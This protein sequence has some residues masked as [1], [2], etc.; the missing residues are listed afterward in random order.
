MKVSQKIY[1]FSI[2][3]RDSTIPTNKAYVIMDIGS[4]RGIH[5][6]CFH[7]KNNKSF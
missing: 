1:N 4:M 3:P 5:W 2:Y 6:T 7:K